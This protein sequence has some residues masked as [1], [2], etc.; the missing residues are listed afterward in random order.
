[1]LGLF[2]LSSG[3]Y[4]VGSGVALRLIELSG[5]DGVFFIPAGITLAFLLR[6]PVQVWWVVLTGAFVTEYVSDVLNGFSYAQSAGFAVANAAEPLLG[7]AIVM[8]TCGVLD[9]ARRRHVV[10]FTVGAVIS[11]PLIGALIV[12]VTDRLF[13]GDDFWTTFFQV[14]LGD[15]LGVIVIGGAVLVWGSSPDRRSVASYWGFVLVFVTVALTASVLVF[16]DQPLAFAGLIGIALAGALFGIRAV[17]V[18]GFAVSL[19]LALVLSID[20]PELLLGLDQGE[21]LVLMKLQVATFTLAGLLIAAEAHERDAALRWATRAELAAQHS[22]RERRREHD[23]AI[24]VQRSLLPDRLIERPGIRLAAHY[25]AA[26]EGYE[27]GG[28]WYDS[29][30]LPDGRFGLVVGDIVG[31]GIGALTSMGRLRTALVALAM[32][33]DR[34]SDL[35]TNLDVFVGGPDGTDYATALYVIVDLKA[36]GLTYASAGHPPALLRRESGE[37][38]W[39]DGGLSGPLYGDATVVRTD[40]ESE[41]GPGDVLILYSDGLIERRGESLSAGMA[42][43]REVVSKSLALDAQS[44]CQSLVAELDPGHSRRDDVVVLV[45]ELL[46]PPSTTYSSV[47]AADADELRHV[48]SSVRTWLTDHGADSDLVENLILGLGE[49][50]SNAVRHAYEGREPG[51]VSIEIVREDSRFEVTVTDTG[52]WVVPDATTAGYGM[53]IMKAISDSLEIEETSH[54]TR[55]HFVIESRR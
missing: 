11:G 51:D 3:L 16:T 10:W 44:L 18:T 52:R 53:D 15:A 42:R 41:I 34:P 5:L 46:S 2:A 23:L 22:D 17:A 29:F 30:E 45:L 55:I 31:H 13:G 32:N 38:E 50:T 19:T 20:S 12:A 54:G 36:S 37:G 35:M 33:A 49:A 21:A 26:V 27:V 43:L 25:E 7:A 6:V 40:G 48:R 8:T 39:L 28:D 47:I 1:V 4:A 14:W 24:R 9:L